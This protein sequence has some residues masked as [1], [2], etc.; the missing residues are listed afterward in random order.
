MKKYNINPKVAKS[1]L[2][3]NDHNKI[4]SI[5]YLLLKKFYHEGKKIVS[6]Y[7]LTQNTMKEVN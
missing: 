1:F 7:T 3:A 6:P 5:Y 4:T 2:E